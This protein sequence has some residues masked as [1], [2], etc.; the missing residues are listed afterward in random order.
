MVYTEDAFIRAFF[1]QIKQE[2]LPAEFCLEF[3][4]Q[5]SWMMNKSRFSSQS[6]MDY[7]S[8]YYVNLKN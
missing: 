7:A 1:L 4:R 8:T 6:L 2:S 5:E 3:G